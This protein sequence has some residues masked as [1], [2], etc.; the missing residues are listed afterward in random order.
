M[1]TNIA[2]AP[3]FDPA[4]PLTNDLEIALHNHYWDTLR[5][6][7]TP[8]SNTS[9]SQLNPEELISFISLLESLDARNHRGH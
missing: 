8:P 5:S 6:D 7:S 3:A 9:L 2:T 4:K 1:R